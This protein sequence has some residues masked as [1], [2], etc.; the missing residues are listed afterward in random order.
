MSP[1]LTHRGVL[2]SFALAPASGPCTLSGYPTVDSGQGGPLIHAQPTLRGYMG[3]LP[4]N[5][6]EPPTVTLSPTQQAH[7]VVEGDAVDAN[8]NQCPTY[9]AL[10]VTPPN[11]TQAFTVATKID[12]CELQ[13]HPITS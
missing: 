13:V 7:A 2:L 1:G 3:G 11:L 10:Q 6:S 9:T 5:V 12:T 4:P 8:G